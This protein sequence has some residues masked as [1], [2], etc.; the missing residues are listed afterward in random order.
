[1]ARP[2]NSK[3]KDHEEKYDFIY[4]HLKDFI[5]E[6]KFKNGTPPTLE[7]FREEAFA[8]LK[9]KG[10]SDRAWNTGIWNKIRRNQLR[11]DIVMHFVQTQVGKIKIIDVMEGK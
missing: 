8:V 3:S 1:M 9:K 6:E 10:F 7:A 5:R 2:K 4:L 11:D